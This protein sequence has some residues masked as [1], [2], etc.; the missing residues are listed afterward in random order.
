MLNTFQPLVQALLRIPLLDR[1]LFA[2]DDGSGVYLRR[3]IMYGAP[4]D[5]DA[6]V[7]SLSDGVQAAKDRDD[8]AVARGVAVANARVGNERG[9]QVDNT[10]G[11]LGDEVGVEDAH[12][13]GQD[14][15]VHLEQ[16][17]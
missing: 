4:G 1:D 12:P 11:E 2:A 8:A 16:V 3:Y 13:T 7:E 15:Q 5:F 14:D 10:T 9:M 17:E 6:R